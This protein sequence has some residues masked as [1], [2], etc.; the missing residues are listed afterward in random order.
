[1]IIQYLFLLTVCREM[2][3]FLKQNYRYIKN[4]FTVF[5]FYSSKKVNETVS[6]FLKSSHNL[7]TKDDKKIMMVTRRVLTKQKR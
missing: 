5:C 7:K 6:G 3:K 1:M 4:V 2:K